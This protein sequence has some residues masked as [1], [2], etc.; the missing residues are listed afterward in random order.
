MSIW[1]FFLQN[2]QIGIVLLLEC[3]NNGTWRN[4]EGGQNLRMDIARSEMSEGSGANSGM[5]QSRVAMLSQS[6]PSL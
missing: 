2:F 3:D 1:S 4:F 6:S 5:W